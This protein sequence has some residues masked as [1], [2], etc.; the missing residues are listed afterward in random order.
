M[1]KYAGITW[2]ISD[3]H[4]DIHGFN[5]VPDQ[6]LSKH[7]IPVSDNTARY[8]KENNIK[9]LNEIEEL[10]V[11]PSSTL[12]LKDEYESYFGEID[13]PKLKNIY[14]IRSNI[15]RIQKYP[16]VFHEGI[17]LDE[18][19]KINS[20]VVNSRLSE[21]EKITL[22]ATYLWWNNAP[23]HKLY[24]IRPD[25]AAL[26]ANARLDDSDI[27]LEPLYLS[28]IDGYLFDIVREILIYP[29]ENDYHILISLFHNMCISGS[30][31]E[32]SIDPEINQAK[33]AAIKY[34]RIFL[35]LLKCEK[36]P[37]EQAR[38]MNIERRKQGN[39]PFK[40]L[41]PVTYSTISLTK[42]YRYKKKQKQKNNLSKDEKE[43]VL[44][45]VSGYFK[46]QAY[47]PGFSKHRRIWIDTFQGCRWVKNGLHYITVK[48]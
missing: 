11:S 18:Y 7:W 30:I 45:N 22:T 34:A 16:D 8:L 26:I 41:S 13:I 44:V 42:R 40:K 17:S 10:A 23:Q 1:N 9:N 24:Q 29:M 47:G 20:Q 19:L 37:I 27:E 31:S 25:A 35:G 2:M 38:E 4:G 33:E 36:S 32:K 46:K 28:S 39:K 48:E 3:I 21:S 15:E 12:M 43:L 14:G 6:T 5:D